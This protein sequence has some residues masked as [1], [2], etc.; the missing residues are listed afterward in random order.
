MGRDNVIMADFAAGF[1]GDLTVE[2]ESIH[3]AAGVQ[4]GR[5]DAPLRSVTLAAEATDARILAITEDA[6]TVSASASASV[7]GAIFTSGTSTLTALA[8]GGIGFAG[9]VDF[10]G[11]T[12]CGARRDGRDRISSRNR[13]GRVDS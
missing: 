7:E 5:P 1:G 4:T 8:R 2:T 10:G 13:R 9:A 11:L 3:I 12:P 6:A